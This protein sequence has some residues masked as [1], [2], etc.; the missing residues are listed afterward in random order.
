VPVTG[1]IWIVNINQDIDEILRS[2]QMLHETLTGYP[3]LEEVLL[4]M[5]YN[6][7]PDIQAKLGQTDESTK[8]V[9][10][11]VYDDIK[12]INKGWQESPFVNIGDARNP[13]VLDKLF[14]IESLRYKCRGGVIKSY[15]FDVADSLMGAEMFKNIGE[16]INGIAKEEIKA[17]KKKQTSLNKEKTETK[18]KVTIEEGDKKTK[19]KNEK[20]T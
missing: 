18:K 7:V 2:K 15:C 8:D 6:R 10:I 9:E 13:E 14:D 3:Q 20:S 16:T 1:I 12:A 11:F 19:T 17:E 5:V 4:Y